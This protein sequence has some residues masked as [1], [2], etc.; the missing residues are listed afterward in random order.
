M[1]VCMCVCVGVRV[2]V[3]GGV[4][5]S[6]WM[7]DKLTHGRT[8]AAFGKDKHTRKQFTIKDIGMEI[9]SHRG[10]EERK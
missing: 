4:E 7:A 6:E 8:Q 10:D 3:W 5:G 9:E 2:C 1:C